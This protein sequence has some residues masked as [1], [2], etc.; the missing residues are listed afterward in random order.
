MFEGGI[1]FRGLVNEERLLKDDADKW[2][3]TD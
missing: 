3:S 2:L 1:S